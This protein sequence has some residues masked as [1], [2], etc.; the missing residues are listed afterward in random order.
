MRTGSLASRSA[1]L[2]STKITLG[3]F[4]NRLPAIDIED[5]QT[6]LVVDFDHANVVVR[7]TV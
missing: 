4:G 1:D 2:V 7:A 5:R 3:R 6:T